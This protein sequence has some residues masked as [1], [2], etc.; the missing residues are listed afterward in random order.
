MGFAGRRRSGRRLAVAKIPT[1]TAAAAAEAWAE[2]PRHCCKWL[3]HH[4]QLRGVAHCLGW[5]PEFE[6][7]GL[8]EHP[9]LKVLVEDAHVPAW[10]HAVA[11]QQVGDFFRRDG[12]AENW[13][14]LTLRLLTLDAVEQRS[15]DGSGASGVAASSILLRAA[16]PADGSGI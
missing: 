13:R 16:R 9:P 11:A 4:L 8:I 15:V 3:E 2:S 12:R 1:I 10:I 6:L 7:D 5:T 14:S